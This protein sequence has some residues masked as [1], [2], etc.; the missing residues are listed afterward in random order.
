MSPFL[1][2]STHPCG[3]RP[4]GNATLIDKV[5]FNPRTRVG[6]DVQI[7][8]WFGSVGV[9]SIHAPVWGATSLRCRP[10]EVS[11]LQSTH[12]CGVRQPSA[13]S[14]VALGLLQSTHPCGV[15][16]KALAGHHVQGDASIHAPVWGATTVTIPQSRK[17]MCFNPRTR[18]GCDLGVDRVSDQ[19][20]ASIHAPVWGATANR[21]KGGMQSSLQSTHPCGVRPGPREHLKLLT[22]FNPRTRVGCDYRPVVGSY[23]INQLQSTH[24]CG[25]RPEVT[26]LS[27]DCFQL[28]STHPCGVRLCYRI[29]L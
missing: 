15:R 1:L 23:K 13:S 29:L 3:V 22:C 12:P 21:I 19:L 11:P 26:N 20:V 10:L 14:A 5:G 9:A 6:C 8:P 28:Q 7:H 27:T 2:Q 4:H 16:H 25:V 24:P 17:P 18:V